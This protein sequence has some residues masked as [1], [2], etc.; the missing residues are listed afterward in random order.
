MLITGA[1]QGCTQMSHSL[2]AT[3]QEQTQTPIKQ[4]Q[5]AGTVQI[6]HFQVNVGSLYSEWRPPGHVASCTRSKH[7]DIFVASLAR[8]GCSLWR[9]ST[10]LV[11]PTLLIPEWANGPAITMSVTVSQIIHCSHSQ[12]I[13]VLVTLPDETN[14][15][16]FF[17]KLYMRLKW[18][19]IHGA[20]TWTNVVMEFKPNLDHTSLRDLQ[21]M[22]EPGIM[23]ILAVQMFTRAAKEFPMHHFDE[24]WASQI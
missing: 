19:I 20:F 16:T 13:G 1:T 6:Q 15:L 3:N 10:S 23:C 12:A 7:P 17:H 9:A 22:H 5:Q 21:S 18:W 4:T 24:C 14:L 2:H 8:H 11:L